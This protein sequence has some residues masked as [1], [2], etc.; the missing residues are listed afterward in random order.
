M[1]VEESIVKTHL[2]SIYLKVGCV[3]KNKLLVLIMHARLV[4]Q[5]EAGKPKQIIIFDTV[6]MYLFYFLLK[7]SYFW[8]RINK[9]T[10]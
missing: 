7:I 10:V 8:G 4:L 5:K 2:K 6:V 9:K 1:F 3:N